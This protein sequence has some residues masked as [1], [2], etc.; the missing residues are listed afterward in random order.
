MKKEKNKNWFGL[1]LRA[2]RRMNM[3]SLR[4]LAEKLKKTY[5]DLN[6]SHSLLY[7]Y[8]K[9][10]LIP[11]S[12]MLIK[13]SK[14]LNVRVEFFFRSIDIGEIE[15]VYRGS[16]ASLPEKEKKAIEEQIKEWM[17]RYMFLES[18]YPDSYKNPS[19]PRYKVEEIEDV[20][21]IAKKI[22]EEWDLGFDPIGN[23]VEVFEDKGI[24]VGIIKGTENFDS[25][26]FW[27]KDRDKRIPAIV[28][29]E[30]IPGDRERFS[31]SHELGH[32]ILEFDEKFDNKIREK[33]IDR[34]A[35]AFLVPDIMVFQ[36][37]GKKRKNIGIDELFA[38]KM[39]YGLSMQGW[40]HRMEDLGIISSSLVRKLRE[41]FSEKGWKRKEPGAQIPFQRSTRMERLVYRALNEG[42]ISKAKASEL[43]RNISFLKSEE[44]SL[45][46]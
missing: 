9:G 36:E 11:D 4:K 19:L 6:V 16:A 10:M 24:K 1:R 12:S 35:G 18:F 45:N 26:A 42:V 46:A 44:V 32:F 2:A 43:V 20:E 29:K 14:A 30:G 8:E 23:I 17:E 25:C 40:I 41:E 37:V 5:P 38:L 34:F 3:M 39:K 13:L 31:I 22:R 33:I 21:E 27:V 28:V 15:P 7:K